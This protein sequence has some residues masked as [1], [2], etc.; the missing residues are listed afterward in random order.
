MKF[1]EPDIFSNSKPKFSTASSESNVLV[2]ATLAK[3]Y[4][5]IG[6]IS[7]VIYQS[8]GLEVNS[9]NFLFYVDNVGYLLKRGKLPLTKD[10]VTVETQVALA[11]W[12]RVQNSEFP[13]IIFS[14][15]ANA[16]IAVDGDHYW[17][18]M[19]F[20]DADFFSGTSGEFLNAGKSVADLF[21]SLSKSPKNLTVDSQVSFPVETALAIVEAAGDCRDN[22]PT[23]FG[24][25]FHLLER[26]WGNIRR[27]LEEVIQL[28]TESI[29]PIGLCHI[30]LHPHNLLMK[31]SRVAAILDIGSLMKASVYSSIAF[32]LFK[33]SRQ[34]IVLKKTDCLNQDFT[35]QRDIVISHFVDN[36]LLPE[37]LDL[38]KYAQI[39]IMR[40]LLLILQLNIENNDSVWN[41]VLP[42]QITA[43]SEAELIFS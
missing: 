5:G 3:F 27:V 4:E 15:Y 33:L 21:Y 30:D 37:G 28:E 40:R 36:G 26:S 20:I 12:L 25:A 2:I 13:E 29:Q 11:S 18:L 41:H 10:F 34:V 24:D 43:L 31:E 39:E 42:V 23:I 1:F 16:K 22:W 9:N 38:R 19:Y 6:D 35:A 7:G 17:C 32:N 8:G 14:K